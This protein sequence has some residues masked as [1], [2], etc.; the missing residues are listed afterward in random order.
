[1]LNEEEGAL[2][3]LE[4]EVENTE[5]EDVVENTTADPEVTL[6]EV[7][8]VETSEPEYTEIEKQALEQGWD[9]KGRMGA[10]AWIVKGEMI[11]EKRA[12]Q[13]DFQAFRKEVDELKRISYEKA[14]KDLEAELRQAVTQADYNQV[15]EIQKEMM[16]LQNKAP[17]DI[18]E[19]PPEVL[20]LFEEF[21]ELQNPISAEDY[22]TRAYAERVDQ[23]YIAANP[24]DIAGSVEY[25][26]RKLNERN[27]KLKPPSKAQQRRETRTPD[28]IASKKPAA[29][30]QSANAEWPKDMSM[31]TEADID[32][33]KRLAKN[34]VYST[35]KE[36][37]DQIKDSRV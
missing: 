4:N 31:F 5:L 1:M 37:L 2:N 8:V 7:E 17:S 11:K 6:E 15:Q 27:V 34:K 21:P 9:P 29:T 22:A 10:E 35:P 25:I 28:T 3:P 19:T 33:A 18:P 23:E 20:E 24:G 30:K 13:K 16:E 26:K 36:Y 12:V 32:M 14:R